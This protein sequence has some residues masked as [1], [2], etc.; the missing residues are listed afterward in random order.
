M[1]IFSKIL[2]GGHKMKRLVCFI[3]SLLILAG[4]LLTSCKRPETDDPVDNDEPQTLKPYTATAEEMV[5]ATES[6]EGNQLLRGIWVTP[7]LRA[8]DSQE[9]Y[10]EEYRKVK[11]AGVNMVFTYDELNYK[12]SMEKLLS[13]CEKNGIK[14][15]ISLGRI[16]SEAEIKFNV[17]KVELYDSNPVVIG[18]NLMDEPNTSSFELLGKEYQA[19]REKCSPDKIIMINFFPNYANAGQLG[20]EDSDNPYR[21]YLKK[22]FEVSRSDVVSF[23]YYPYR[24]DPAGDDNLIAKALTNMQEIVRAESYS[25]AEGCWGFVQS[26]EWSGTRTP[27]LGELRFISHLHLL[28]GFKAFTYFLYVTPIDGETAEGF[29]KGLVEY[30]GTIR[31]TYGL[32]KQTAEEIDGMKGVYLDYDFTG[33][34]YDKIPESYISEIQ[35][36]YDLV[37]NPKGPFTSIKA[38]GES[39]IIAGYFEKGISKQ[40]LYVLNNDRYYDQSATVTLSGL[41]E[42]RV[43]GENGIEQM[44]AANEITVEL[45]SGEAKFIEVFVKD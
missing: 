11:E 37:K 23:D 7:R 17:K 12:T 29:F 30:D 32:V 6:F 44:G 8:K 1:V 27:K 18:Y 10:D 36:D 3:I 43:W 13:A 22:Y 19:V 2:T 39:G 45:R 24:S 28:F 5:E 38:S 42:Y 9:T 31:D 21:D 4:C 33:L 34:M 25:D 41:M 14:V 20:V 16:S 15:M 40:G 26:G 35:D